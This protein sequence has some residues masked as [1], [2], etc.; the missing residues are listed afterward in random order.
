[1]F[2]EDF[3]HDIGRPAIDGRFLIHKIPARHAINAAGEHVNEALHSRLTGKFSE[4]N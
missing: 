2:D 4:T 1:V 3:S